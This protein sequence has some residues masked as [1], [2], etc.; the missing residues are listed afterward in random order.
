MQI[1]I[2]RY[3]LSI[4]YNFVY[5][6]VLINNKKN[7]S[8]CTLRQLE[9]SRSRTNNVSLRTEIYL[10][11]FRKNSDGSVVSFQKDMVKFMRSIFFLLVIRAISIKNAYSSSK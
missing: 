10:K 1:S 7:Y 4:V 11:N 5:K 9:S 3:M 6:F 8:I 2:N